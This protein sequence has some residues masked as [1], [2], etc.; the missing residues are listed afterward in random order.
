[1]HALF[2]QLTEALEEMNIERSGGPDGVE[3]AFLKN[4]PEASRE[5][6]LKIINRRYSEQQN[7]DEWRSSLLIPIP[8][9]GMTKRFGIVLLTSVIARL[10][11]RMISS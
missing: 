3:I 8:K 11:E 4:L 2:D 9:P 1:M 5:T 10:A 6:L 7:S